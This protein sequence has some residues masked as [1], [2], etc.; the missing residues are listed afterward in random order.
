[1][2]LREADREAQFYQVSPGDRVIE[3]L[4]GPIAPPP[5]VE[6]LDFGDSRF[7]VPSRDRVKKDLRARHRP[8]KLY[9]AKDRRSRSRK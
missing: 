3:K 5:V 9:E 2:L 1:M 8:N 4:A 7:D 6:T